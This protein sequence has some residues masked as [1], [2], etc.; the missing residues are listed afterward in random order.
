MYWNV[1]RIVP[2]SVTGDSCFVAVSVARLANGDAGLAKPKSSSF[3]PVGVSMKTALSLTMLLFAT[4]AGAQ[5]KPDEAAIRSILQEEV[6]AWNKRDAQA[7]SQHFT[8]DGLPLNFSGAIRGQQE[9]R[10]FLF[11][12]LEGQAAPQNSFVSN[13]AVV[14]IPNRPYHPSS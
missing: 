13:K 8:A 9:F 11:N 10:S 7:Y 6:T 4:M 5:G 2:C 3:A 1:P 12:T 14:S